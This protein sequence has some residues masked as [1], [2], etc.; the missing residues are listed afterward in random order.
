VLR[1]RSWLWRG[2]I[3]EIDG[4]AWI[5]MVC[6]AVAGVDTDWRDS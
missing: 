5:S 3:L 6:R 4:M 2:C 1:M